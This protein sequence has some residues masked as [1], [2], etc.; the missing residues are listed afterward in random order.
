M[1]SLARGQRSICET[2]S[3]PRPFLRTLSPIRPEGSAS[4]AKSLS[5]AI[6]WV[7]V[8]GTYRLCPKAMR[9]GVTTVSLE[10]IVVH[11]F[12]DRRLLRNADF[13]SSRSARLRALL[14]PL[15]L[16]HADC[17]PD[18]TKR[19][20]A[21]SVSGSRIMST[22]RRRCQ[23]SIVD[24]RPTHSLS[25]YEAPIVSTELCCRT[26]D[27]AEFAV[28][29]CLSDSEQPCCLK[30]AAVRTAIGR[31]DHLSL[32]FGHRGE[33]TRHDRFRCCELATPSARPENNPLDDALHDLHNWLRQ[34]CTASPAV[35]SIVPLDKL[36]ASAANLL[37]LLAHRHTS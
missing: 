15:S 34:S 27:L 13:E 29:S 1:S 20:S 10:L 35:A 25:E 4:N 26:A 3:I 37:P 24:L 11:E 21:G 2:R 6:D 17:L 14:G 19:I 12:K 8:D 9:Y 23:T 36:T 5:M 31:K 33:R 28:K 18:L 7:K 16:R 22:D 32:N 30:R